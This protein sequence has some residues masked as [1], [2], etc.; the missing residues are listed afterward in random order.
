VW[1]DGASGA[2]EWRASAPIAGSGRGG[3]LRKER[4]KEDA[5]AG[6]AEA[7]PLPGKLA[8][9]D[10]MACMLGTPAAPAPPP[11]SFEK[12]PRGW[13]W[14]IEGTKRA[15]LLDRDGNVIELRFP[16]GEVV[17]FQPGEGVPRRIEAKGPDGR[18]VLTLETYGP[19]PAGDE[20]PPL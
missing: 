18:A 17:S 20:V 12:T 5:A 6:D 1:W 4:R 14:R 10:L 3:I 9:A 19:W 16:N 7:V 2:L 8:A 11:S 15:A 13:S